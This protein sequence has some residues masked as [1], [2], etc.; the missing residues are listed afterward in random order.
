MIIDY[1]ESFYKKNNFPIYLNSDP[2][3]RRS[4]LFHLDV[5]NIPRDDFR[6]VTNKSQ[7]YKN[8]NYFLIYPTNSNLEKEMNDYAVAYDVINKK[9]FGTKIVSCVL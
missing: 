4:F 3:Y 1:M 9:Q 8:G 6:N 7:V 5:R 2:Y